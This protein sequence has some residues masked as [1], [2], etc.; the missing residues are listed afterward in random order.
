M[1]EREKLFILSLTEI[2]RL[3]NNTEDREKNLHKTLAIVGQ[4]T[5]AR[6]LSIHRKH[7]ENQTNFSLESFSVWTAPGQDTGT[8]PRLQRRPQTPYVI[9]SISPIISSE[10]HPRNY[11]F[12]R[13]VVDISGL[14]CT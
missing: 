4:I 10:N 7:Y 11:Y 14:F 3:L 2:S 8:F 6:T 13:I 9:S 1:P 5:G 12:D